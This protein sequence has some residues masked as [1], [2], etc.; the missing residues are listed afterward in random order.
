MNTINIDFNKS[1]NLEA[2]TLDSNAFDRIGQQ[3]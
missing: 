3:G 2:L 1:A